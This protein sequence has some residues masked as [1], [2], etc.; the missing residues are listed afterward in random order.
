M[1]IM[2]KILIFPV[3][4]LQIIVLIPLI[5]ITTGLFMAGMVFMSNENRK[6]AIEQLEEVAKSVKERK[7]K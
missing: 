4:S 6:K 2:K 7:K 1:K 5:S 3:T